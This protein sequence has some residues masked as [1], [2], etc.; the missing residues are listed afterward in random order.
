MEINAD[1][2]QRVV[3]TPAEQCLVPSPLPGVS[4]IMLDRI[5]GEVARATSIVHYAA[6]SRF[7]AHTHAGGEEFLV[8]DGV[9]SDSSGDYGP[10]SY[11]R[12]PRGTAHAPWS[13]GGCTIFV[14][15]W[16]FQPG[17]SRSV[18]IDTRRATGWGPGSA[19]GIEV[20]KLHEFS[21][22]RVNL[23]R[24]A[25]GAQGLAHGH[26]G[27]EEILVLDG[28]YSDGDGT[29][30]AGTWIRSP[31]GSGYTPRSDTG[32]LLYVKTGHLGASGMLAVP[33][34]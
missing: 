21:D 13:E 2:S 22:E 1:F 12:N 4:R 27:G 16:Q 23:I 33:A 17:D 14:K 20:L 5:G 26:P 31:V 28:R 18:A 6:K 32:C 3:I 19:P 11:V 15:L 25:P 10:G 30:E 8:L 7:D 9:F 29:Y 24:F 34:A